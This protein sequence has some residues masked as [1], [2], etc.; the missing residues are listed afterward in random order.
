[1]YPQNAIGDCF[2]ILNSKN[3]DY[4]V[5]PF[6][7]S[8]NG[9]VV[10]TYDLIRDW[11]TPSLNKS[12]KD[13]AKF[14]IVGEQFVSIHHNL[15][16]NATSIANVKTLYSHPQV[17]TQVK[18][19]MKSLP[20]EINIVDTSSTSKAAELVFNDKTNTCA[21][22][23]S[24]MS[25]DLYNLPIMQANIEDNPKNS[26]RFLILGYEPLTKPNENDITSIL[27]T[28]NHDNPG[29]LCDALNCFKKN[30]VNLNCISSRPSHIQQWQYVFFI[31]MDGNIENKNVE[32]SIQDMK[33]HILDLVVLGSFERSKRYI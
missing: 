8:T 26:T 19:F 16:S 14:K 33:D 18:R 6:E 5:V 23:S 3:V 4:A 22:I 29:A 1:M 11:Y 12:S 20:K 32:K 13:L 21:C 28:L 24:K 17:W 9:P 15:L 2:D 7:N 31:E 10:F 27:F 30:Q 25:S